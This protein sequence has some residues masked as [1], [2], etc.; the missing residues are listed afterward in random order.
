MSMS[1]TT[2]NTTGDTPW[3]EIDRADELVDRLIEL[4]ETKGSSRYDEAVTQSEHAV[5]A[6]ELAV[7][8]GAD[9]E[10]VAAALL[11]DIGHLLLDEHER[12][13]EFLDQDL[14][15]EEVAARFL[16]NWF[17]PGVVEP[18]RL[19]VAAKRYL[20]AVEHDYHDGLSPASVR[21]LEVQG[22]PMT[23]EE[24]EAFAA[25]NG[26]DGATLL[27]RWDDLAKDGQRPTGLVRGHRDLLT[28]LA[29]LPA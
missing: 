29:T 12:R 22:G 21:S 20:C 28:R 14:H 13:P 9:D 17:G 8:A 3:M 1:E 27:R 18:V 23:D 16:A 4:Y 19:H 25:L 5:Q 2:G 6:A 24:A 15:H 7:A 26:S 11:H 10:L